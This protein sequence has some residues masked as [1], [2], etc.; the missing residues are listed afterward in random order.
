[1]TVQDNSLLMLKK[2]PKYGKAVFAA[3]D[4]EKDETIAVWDGPVYEAENNSDLPND[5]PWMI[6]D[7]AIQFEKNRWRDS[8]GLA[9]YINHSC[10]PNCGIK[11]LFNIVAMRKINKGEEITWDYEMTENSDWQMTCQC[12]K[13]NCR[14]IIRAYRFLP[15]EIKWKYQ[16][17]ISEWLK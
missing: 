15:D 17:Y 1:M 13:D 10:E 2:T 4:I 6:A 16:N 11:G 5:F 12:G 9:R 3:E 14:K 8:E 7:H